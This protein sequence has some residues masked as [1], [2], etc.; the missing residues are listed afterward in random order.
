MTIGQ[1]HGTL[2]AAVYEHH[3]GL[4]AEAGGAAGVR[5]EVLGDDRRI[6]AGAGHEVFKSNSFVPN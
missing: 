6:L 5:A 1:G 2:L 3:D 4:E